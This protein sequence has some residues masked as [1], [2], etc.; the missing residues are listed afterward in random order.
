MYDGNDFSPYLGPDYWVLLND[1][2]NSPPRPRI[3][4]MT[5]Q[6]IV[7][8][9]LLYQIIKKLLKP[10]RVQVQTERSES[11]A[12]KEYKKMTATFLLLLISPCFTW[13]IGFVSTSFFLVLALGWFW[14]Q[15]SLLNFA[16]AEAFVVGLLYGVFQ[17]VLDVPF[18]AGLLFG[19]KHPAVLYG[20]FPRKVHSWLCSTL[21]MG[22]GKNISKNSELQMQLC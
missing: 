11:P 20:R 9:F 5:V 17:R 1:S 12:N 15:R 21:F 16:L 14:G 3:L 13:L 8:V 22:D 2:L 19:G 7:L 4:P 10:S 18:P 6:I